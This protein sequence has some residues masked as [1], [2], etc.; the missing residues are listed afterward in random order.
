MS[1]R[2]PTH[3]TLNIG[4]NQP[5]KPD[6]NDNPD[7][8]RWNNLGIGYLDALQYSSAVQAFGEVVKLRPGYADS[9]TNIAVTE[10]SWEKYGSAWDNIQKA[11]SLSPHNARALY[12]AALLER[13][14]SH[15]K[16]ELSDL[17]EVV[18]QYPQ[19][20]NLKHC[21]QSI[22]TTFQHTITSLFSTIG[23]AW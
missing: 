12:Y 5:E 23:W 3:K 8:M 16:E 17:L 1:G 18:R 7:W 15:P 11:L 2:K 6:V 10:I 19:S 22:R 21:R 13:R 9:Y 4:E 20:L 14:A